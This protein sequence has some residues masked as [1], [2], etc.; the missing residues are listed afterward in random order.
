MLKNII[1]RIVSITMALLMIALPVAARALAAPEALTFTVNSTLDQPD[2]LT[3]PGTCHTA[4]NTCTLRAAVMQA[5]RTTGQDAIIL[6]P[7]GIYSLTIPFTGGDGEENGDLNLTS[8]VAGSPT[9]TI[10]GAGAGLTFIVSNQID[11]VF[12]VHPYRLVM[13][14]DV[15]IRN[16]YY[17]SNVNANGGGVYNE[18]SLAMINTTISANKAASYGGGIYNSLTGYLIV[19]NSTISQN[20]ADLAGGGIYNSGFLIVRNSTLSENNA[21]AFGGGITNTGR[22]KVSKSTISGNGSIDGGG[23]F[24]SGTNNLYVI[25]STI[26][27]NYAN[28]NG[29]EST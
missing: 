3:I 10:N 12:H 13:I 28:N 11:R 22:T 26:S 23:I 1:I 17:V 27:Q 18:G 14:S 15:T 2:D 20:Y 8:P 4:A 25:N 16:G 29:G 19:E 21:R 7:A 9:I 5:N 24:S 6:L